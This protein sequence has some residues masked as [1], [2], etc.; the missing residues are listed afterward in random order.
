LRIFRTYSRFHHSFKLRRLVFFFA[1]PSCS[2]SDETTPA[3]NTSTVRVF[4]T[5]CPY[6]CQIRFGPRNILLMLVCS[7][8]HCRPPHAAG[9]DD[10]VDMHALGE[11]QRDNATPEIKVGACRF[12]L[13]VIVLL[14]F[15]VKLLWHDTLGFIQEHSRPR[16]L[17]SVRFTCVV[18]GGAGGCCL[19]WWEEGV[20]AGV[21]F[22]PRV[23]LKCQR[24]AL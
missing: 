20:C 8:A 17:A 16:M 11:R 1:S 6:A 15:W 23:S 22:H 9:G 7:P 5:A 21:S 24:R 3:L 10:Y 19:V 18:V 13:G 12:S 2:M 14:F 4:R